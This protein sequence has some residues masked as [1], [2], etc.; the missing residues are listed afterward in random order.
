MKIRLIAPAQEKTQGKRGLFPP[1]SLAILAGLTPDT[2]E[3]EVVDENVEAHE[4]D[5]TPDLVGITAITSVAP[6]AYKIARAYRD[7]GVPVVMGG[8]HAS[9]LPDEALQHVDSVVIGEAEP[10]WQDVLDDLSGGGLSPLYQADERPCLSQLP[11]PRWEVFNRKRYVTTSLL[12]TSRGCPNN[13]QFCSVTQFFGHTFR[14]R[15]IEAVLAEIKAMPASN[16][17]LFVDDN[18][19]G[20]RRYACDLFREL[21]ALNIR[22]FGQSSLAIAWD[23]EMLDLAAESGCA[24]LFIGFESLADKNL[25]QMQKG[26]VNQA[27]RFAE[28]VKRIFARGIGIEGAFIFGMDE[29]DPSVFARTLAFAER[30]RLSLAQFGILTPFPGTPLYETLTAQGRIVE[31]DWSKYTISNAVAV[32]KKMSQ[33]ALESGFLWTYRQFYS[34]RSILKRLLPR[35]GKNFWLFL[36]LN[37]IF[38]RVSK[39]MISAKQSLLDAYG[40]EIENPGHNP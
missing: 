33:Q 18:I 34:Y 7:L 22:W 19:V 3:V 11:R 23:D 36:T 17:I 29:D 35:L 30:A 25:Q 37:M 16:L 20:N 14:T 15:P 13:C 40:Q 12:Q 1:L 4:V 8:M 9:A 5:D 38:R 2:W 21:R 26:G 28:A 32:P 24:G 6:R 27:E 39:G 10:V 31:T